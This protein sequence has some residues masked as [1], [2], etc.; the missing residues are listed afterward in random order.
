MLNIC[1]LKLIYI[2]QI[3]DWTPFSS[4]RLNLAETSLGAPIVNC[5][6]TFEH[7]LS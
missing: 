3:L 6:I 2:K 5:I 1:L 7:C 4:T